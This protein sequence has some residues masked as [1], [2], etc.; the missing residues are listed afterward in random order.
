MFF[1]INSVFV[2]VNFLNGLHTS[3]V[4]REICLGSLRYL[5]WL[6]SFLVI[7]GWY[8]NNTGPGYTPCLDSILSKRAPLCTWNSICFCLALE[9]LNGISSLFILQF[10]PDLCYQHHNWLL[11]YYVMPN[12]LGRSLMISSIFAGTCHLLVPIWMTILWTCTC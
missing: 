4:D 6:E 10:C 1:H 9:F 8:L 5:K 3:V 2:D 11:N 12:T 7:W